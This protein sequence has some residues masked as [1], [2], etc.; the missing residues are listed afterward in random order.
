MTQNHENLSK[1]TQNRDKKIRINNIKKHQYSLLFPIIPYS[2]PLL[3]HITPLRTL[4]STAPRDKKTHSPPHPPP[5]PHSPSYPIL[6][7]HS[8]QHRHV[9]A[10]SLLSPD[11][12]LWYTPLGC[13]QPI[14]SQGILGTILKMMNH[15]MNHGRMNHGMMTSLM[16]SLMMTYLI[17]M[18]SL[19]MT[20]QRPR[21][22]VIC[23]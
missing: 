5:Q 12:H 8:L 1:L 23:E 15:M 18:T 7:H 19:M 22:C 16:T 21:G 17:M 13:H 6:P 3:P 4:F 2:S 10:Y 9:T 14:G 11:T 20:Y